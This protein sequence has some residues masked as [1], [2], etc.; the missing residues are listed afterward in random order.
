[1]PYDHSIIPADVGKLTLISRPAAPVILFAVRAAAG[2]VSIQ[3]SR[4]IRVFSLDLVRIGI[5][6]LR[7]NI[8]CPAGMPCTGKI[9]D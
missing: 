4:R 2:I 5:E 3:I 6:L 7:D 9:H 8:S 1:M